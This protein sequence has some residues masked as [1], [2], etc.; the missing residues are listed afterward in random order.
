MTIALL[1]SGEFTEAMEE[2]DRFIFRDLKRPV[3][4]IVP[5]AAKKESDYWKWVEMGEKHFKKLGVEAYGAETAEE[6]VKANVVYFS[7]GDPGHLLEQVKGEIW[8]EAKKKQVVCGSSAGAMLLG[9]WMLANIYAVVDEGEK[10]LQWEKAME[11]VPYTIWP[12]FDWAL[13]EMPEKMKEFINKA[14]KGDW[15]GIDEDTAVIFEGKPFF[16]KATK[17]KGVAHW[18]MM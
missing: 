4:A 10:K 15:L 8:N 12:H 13:R 2:V 17:G 3:I 7:G 16:A 5:L 1:G 14:P 18:C 9:E 11:V 6:L